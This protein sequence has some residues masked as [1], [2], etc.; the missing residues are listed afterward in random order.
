MIESIQDAKLR[1]RL[2]DLTSK[3]E[4]NLR[5]VDPHGRL[6]GRPVTYDLIAG[7]TF[8]IT[9]SGVERIDETQ[10]IGIKKLI[11]ETCYCS[12]EPETAS[13]LRVRFVVPL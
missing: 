1:E 8:E 5:S 11:G 2:T 4:S 7:Q 3:L 6:T 13:T 12:V 9:Y 10:V